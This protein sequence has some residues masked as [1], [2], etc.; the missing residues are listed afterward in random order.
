LTEIPDSLQNA[1]M[2][3]LA[4]QEVNLGVGSF[5]APICNSIED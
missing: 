5:F 4:S 1:Q 3:V 2:S